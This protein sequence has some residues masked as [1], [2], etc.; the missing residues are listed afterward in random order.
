MK[1]VDIVI[2]STELMAVGAAFGA[3]WLCESRPTCVI[4]SLETLSASG[5]NSY[6][7]AAPCCL[8]TPL[9]VKVATFNRRPSD[10]LGRSYQSK[11][12]PYAPEGY[13]IASDD[14]RE[15]R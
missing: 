14:A 4:V 8:A 3:R 6:L 12:T 5:R 15:S 11:V 7:P 10:R 9:T 2:G 1:A 13:Q